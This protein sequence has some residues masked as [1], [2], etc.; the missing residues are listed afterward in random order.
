MLTIV[1]CHFL[2]MIKFTS[3]PSMVW[4]VG[5][6]RVDTRVHAHKQQATYSSV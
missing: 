1:I 6:G 5:G 4:C 3:V 2:L